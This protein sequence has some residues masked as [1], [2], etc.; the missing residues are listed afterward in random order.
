M[1]KITLNLGTETYEA[2]GLKPDEAI[3][4]L[5]TPT[6]KTR[7]DF[8]LEHDGKRAILQRNRIRT[9]MILTRP[10]FAYFMGLHLTRLLK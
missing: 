3:L 5:K 9:Q 10:N 7:G 2:T 1:Y 4:N 6:V 8:T